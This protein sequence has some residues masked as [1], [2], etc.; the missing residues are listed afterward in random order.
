MRNLLSADFYRYRKDILLKVAFI[1]IAFFVAM[2]CGLYALLKNMVDDESMLGDM[3][4]IICGRYLYGAA[5]SVGSNV[6]IVIPIFAGAIVCKDFSMG[7]IRNKIIRGYDRKQIYMSHF[8]TSIAFGAVL[9]AIYALA[10]LG[11]GSL[12]LG[13]SSGGF[14]AEQGKFLAVSLIGGMLVFAAMSAIVTLFA[15][16]TGSMGLSIVLYVAIILG[17]SIIETVVMMIPKVPKFIKTIVES[18]PSSL[19]AQVCSGGVDWE[20]YTRNIVISIVLIVL[21]CIG[22]MI[23]FRNKDQK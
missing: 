18:L 2:N 12:L 20:Y 6:G 7:T 5:F 10:N 19:Y 21:F 23:I 9:F 8:I 17:L 4:D 13:Y 3:A 14:D 22:G 15:T 16:S 11:F 1:L